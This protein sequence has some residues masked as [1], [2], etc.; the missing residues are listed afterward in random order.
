MK[1]TSSEL[2]PAV[3]ADLRERIDLIDQAWY[4]IETS[5]DTGVAPWEDLVPLRDRVTE[6]RQR[7]PPDV[8]TAEA[9]TTRAF[10]MMQ[11]IVDA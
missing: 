11:G 3:A 5:G 4:A 9:I 1:A 10:M 2:S 7:N 6:C 8:E